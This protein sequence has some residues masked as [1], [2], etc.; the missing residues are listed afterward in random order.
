MKI[1]RNSFTLIELLVV[2]AIIAILTSLLLPALKNA[3]E[4][5][6]QTLCTNNLKQLG[7]RDNPVR[8][9]CVINEV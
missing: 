8:I 5:A 3:K 6:K 9:P 7:T 4:S 2:L 1:E